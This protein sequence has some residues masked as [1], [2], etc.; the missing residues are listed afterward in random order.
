MTLASY[1]LGLPPSVS[2][3]FSTGH[4]SIVNRKYATHKISIITKNFF[5]SY[6]LIIGSFVIV[7]FLALPLA[8]LFIFFLLLASRLRSSV[9]LRKDEPITHPKDYNKSCF[10]FKA[11]PGWVIVIGNW[12][13]LCTYNMYLRGG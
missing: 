6:L 4:F 9:I 5:Q 2:S 1:R 11:C 8:I 12:M 7:V 13:I 10:I 3:Q